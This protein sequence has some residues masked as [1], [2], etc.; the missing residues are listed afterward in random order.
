MAEG[1]TTRAW[2]KKADEAERTIVGYVSP[3]GM[4]TINIAVLEQLMTDAGWVPTKTEDL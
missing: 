3:T 4:I 2:T 1:W